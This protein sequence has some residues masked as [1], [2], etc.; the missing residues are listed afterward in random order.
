MKELLPG[1]DPEATPRVVFVD[2]RSAVTRARRR[3]V[4]RDVAQLLLLAGVDWLFFHWPHSHVPMMDRG[5]SLLI[6]GALNAGM[7]IYMIVVRALPRWSARRVASTWSV[8]E[9]ARFSS[10]GRGD[11]PREQRQQNDRRDGDRNPEVLHL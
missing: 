9:R 10:E 6:V 7:L 11:Q 2:S 5:H 8:T 3:A 4:I 1:I